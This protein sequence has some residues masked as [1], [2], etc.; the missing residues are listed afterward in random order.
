M[1][2]AALI[3]QATPAPQHLPTIVVHAPQASLRLQVANTED[4]RETGLM[5]VTKLPAHTGMVF[6]FDADAAVTFWMKDTLVSLDMVFV[7]ADGTVRSVAANVPVVPETAPDDTIPRRAGT[8]QYVIELPAGEA[9]TD[10]IVSGTR[11]TGLPMPVT[12]S[13][14]HAL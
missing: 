6:V 3:A 10:G 5:S 2:L 12:N 8:A 14:Q 4:E 13:A 1:I 11:L 7:A 9:A